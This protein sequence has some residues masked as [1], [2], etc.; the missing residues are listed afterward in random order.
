MR[1]LPRSSKLEVL[2]GVRDVG[3]GAVDPGLLERLVELAP[4]RPDERPALA[5]LRSPGCS[6]TRTNARVL[7][8]LAEHR[9]RRGPPE[10]AAA[11][12]RGGVAQRVE[13]AALGQ[14]RR[15]VGRLLGGH[16]A[17]IPAASAR[18]PR[19]WPTA[20]R[21]QGVELRGIEPLTSAA[22]AALSQLSY[23]PK[24]VIG[25]RPDTDE[26]AVPRGAR[27]RC[28]NVRRSNS[29]IGRKK[30]RSSSRQ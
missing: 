5:V 8:P 3:L 7:R 10:V 20:A 29:A 13:R 14:E 27:R 21:P 9:L 16:D 24:R 25:S 28:A 26:L 1:R 4:G 22:N 23:S 18:K 30:Q 17:N 2:D 6:P 15:R 19:K 12:V 11:A